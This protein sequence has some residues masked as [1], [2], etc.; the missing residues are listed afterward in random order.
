MSTRNGQVS[1]S[2]YAVAN[3]KGGVGKTTTAVNL[4]AAFAS[5][6]R[7]TLLIDLDQ[8]ANATVA[9]G[10]AKNLKPSSYE[11]LSGECQ[12]GDAI[13]PGPMPNLEVIPASRDLAGSA[14]ELA[15][16]TDPPFQLSRQLEPLGGQYEVV[17]LDCPPA[18]GLVTVNALVAS[19]RVIV[20]VQAE[21]LALEGLIEFL[22]TL[23]TV[24]RELNPSLELAGVVVTMHDE[25]TRLARDVERD[26]RDHFSETVFRTV[27]PRTVRLAE[28]P[29]YG[30][31][32]SEYA[33]GSRGANAYQALAEEVIERG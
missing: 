16:V 24:R 17:L 33:P 23:S 29:S 9:L 22:D 8:Q 15:S 27:V 7:R 12:A 10:L 4:A 20:P 21:Y 2:V 28:A 14:V 19:D 1:F 26:V 11:L 32:V 18:L 13:V 3:Q 25:R 30:L 31:P 5:G 6:G